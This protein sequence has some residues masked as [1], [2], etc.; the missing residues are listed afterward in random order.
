[1]VK[2]G[3]GGGRDYIGQGGCRDGWVL[4]KQGANVV[5][6]DECRYKRYNNEIGVMNV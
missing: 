5:R 2:H 4:V 1:M 3:L 6:R